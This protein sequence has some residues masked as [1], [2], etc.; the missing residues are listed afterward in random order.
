M[1]TGLILEKGK[2]LRINYTGRTIKLTCQA[3]RQLLKDYQV[4]DSIAIN[5]VCLTAV[6]KTDQQFTVDIMPE[7]FQ[8][9]TFSRL[10]INDEVNLERA[11]PYNGRLE[12]HLVTGHIDGV[13]RLREKKTQENALI[14]TFD[15]PK[16]FQGEIISQ[17][18][19]AING[20]SLTITRVTARSFSISL[21]PHSRNQTNLGKLM[22]GEYV[23]VETDVLGKYVK[24]QLGMSKRIE[25]KG[26]N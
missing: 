9:T 11:L 18:S 13:M 14:L 2:V 23:N 8:R 20:V 10:N 3:S 22:Y 4:G 1:F 5:G 19:I 16:E 21:I 25:W 17:G 15:F 6:G 7:T 12:G 26:L 24:A